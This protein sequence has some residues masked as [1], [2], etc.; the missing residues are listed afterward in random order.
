MNKNSVTILI[1][2]A[3]LVSNKVS[4]PILSE[5]DLTLSQYRVLKYLY[6]L[7]N[8]PARVVDIEKECSIRHPT[9]LGLLNHLEE[10]GFIKRTVNPDDGRSSLISLTDQAISNR[11]EIENVGLKIESMMTQN[12]SEDE[13]IQLIKLLQKMLGIKDE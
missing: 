3:A 9:A 1:K 2:T 8:K 7:E 10:K 12:L 6:G 4:N 13:K 11:S 5:Y